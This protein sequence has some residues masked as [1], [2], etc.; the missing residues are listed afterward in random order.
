MEAD[1]EIYSQALDL[2][3]SDQ[4]KRGRSDNMTKAVKTMI[5]TAD[6]SY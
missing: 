1:T 4:P 6:L 3:S 5:E 2:A